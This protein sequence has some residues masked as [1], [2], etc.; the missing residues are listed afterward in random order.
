MRV[1]FAHPENFCFFLFLLWVG[2]MNVGLVGYMMY[3]LIKGWKEK[4]DVK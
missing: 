4:R 3:D 1:I 2:V